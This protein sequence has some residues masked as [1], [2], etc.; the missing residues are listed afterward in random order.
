M[1]MKKRGRKKEGR[2]ERQMEI[3]VKW[4]KRHFLDQVLISILHGAQAPI[5]LEGKF[6]SETM[7]YCFLY[8]FW[9]KEPVW[10]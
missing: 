6:F 9:T 1:N 4:D 3:D 8:R 5:D 7:V 2:K 10:Q